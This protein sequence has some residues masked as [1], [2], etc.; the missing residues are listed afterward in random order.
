MSANDFV[1]TEQQRTIICHDGHAFIQACPGAGKTRTMVERARRLLNDR[2][3]LRGVAFL[4]FTNAA[5][6]ELETRLRTLEV[7]PTPLFPNFIGT[8]DSFLWQFFIAPFGIEGSKSPPRLVP[9]KSKWEVKPFDGAHALKLEHFDRQTGKVLSKEVTKDGFNPRY[10]STAW[11]TAAQNLISR[12]IEDGLL[13]FDDVRA[14]V[15][16]RLAQKPFANR[17]GAA[18]AGRFREIVVDE[19][20]DCNPADLDIV[21]W[22]RSSGIMTKV[23]CDPQ[24]AIYRFRGGLTDE[25]ES[26]QDT[27][28]AH[29]R[30]PMSGNFRSSPA[31]CA[32]ISQLRPPAF[33]SAV[34][35]PLGC[36]KGNTTPVHILAYDGIRVPEV[37]GTRFHKL[38]QELGILPASAPVLASTLSSAGNAIG[39]AI[40]EP[41]NHKTLI[42]AEAVMRIHLAFAIGRQRE[43]LAHLH[44]SV[45]SVRGHISHLSDY[46]S[47]VTKQNLSDGKWRPSII[48]IGQKLRLRDNE[49]ADQW[50][51]RAHKLLDVDLIGNATIKQRLKYTT[52]L[53]GILALTAPTAMSARTMHSVKGLEFPAVCVVLTVP[54]QVGFWTSCA[55]LQVTQTRSKTL[56]KSMWPRREQSGSS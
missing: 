7:L 1:P 37:I 49:K 2:Q 25:L 35:T 39:L 55:V 38:T 5:V 23:I 15:S 10:G 54:K 32:A 47:H 14:C 27:F 44:R 16:K 52:E 24:Q 4:S 34:D 42:F 17:L 30:L 12:S 50:L 3:D 41:S 13:D 20:Q 28:E 33:R 6:N 21:K 48:E 8:F 19:A 29:E 26:F 46:S 56:G 40:A 22:L 18:L 9:D 53:P 11:E 51:Q 36:Y 45:L 43:A 31:I